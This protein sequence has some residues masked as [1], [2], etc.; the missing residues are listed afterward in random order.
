MRAQI[1]HKKVVPFFYQKK[2]RFHFVGFSMN[3]LLKVIIDV[4]MIPSVSHQ[5]FC[6][7]IYDF[8]L[9]FERHKL[10]GAFIS[11]FCFAAEIAWCINVLL[12][13]MNVRSFRVYLFVL[14]MCT[15]AFFSLPLAHF[16]CLPFLLTVRILSISMC[17]GECIDACM[18]TL[19]S[20]LKVS[21]IPSSRWL[22]ECVLMRR[23]ECYFK[24]LSHS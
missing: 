8:P 15:V 18:H 9:W 4:V 16:E 24:R 7:C 12:K 6:M 10:H 13:A 11:L 23:Y 1:F 17:L 5:M 19:L 21:L 20:F 14:P 2:K 3:F 22:C